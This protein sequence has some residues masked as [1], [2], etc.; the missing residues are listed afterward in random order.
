M[1]KGR[2]LKLT[3]VA[4]A[5]FVFICFAVGVFAAIKFHSS[6]FRLSSSQVAR[7]VPAAELECARI[8][9]CGL[10]PGDILV[11][12]YIT[13]KTRF[14]DEFVHP[15]FTHAV[16]YLGDGQI[17]EAAGTEKDHSQE[18][19]ISG[20]VDGGWLDSD[21]EGFAIIRPKYTAENLAFIK[22]EL[23]N[24]ADDPDYRFGPPFLD[25]KQTTCADLILERMVEEKIVAAEDM[26]NVATP[27]YL[28]WLAA[29]NPGEFE[30]SGY[31]FSEEK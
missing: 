25:A 20:L 19:R 5:C 14:F 22:A 3:A 17:V 21:L 10:L 24:I 23:V 9:D 11:R 29:E 7:I 16:F 26:S 18:V 12:R 31:G 2:F 13:P 15:Y 6:I 4:A 27:D 1:P 30:I 28:F 8:D